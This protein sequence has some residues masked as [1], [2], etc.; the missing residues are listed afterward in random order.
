MYIDGHTIVL[1]GGILSAIIAFITL[2]WKLFKWINHQKEQDEEIKLLKTMH[3]QD[4]KDLKDK[5]EQDNNSTQDEQTIVIYGLLACLK[6]LQ[7]QGCNGPVTEAI[8]KIE[9]HINQKAHRKD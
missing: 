4:I 9:K 7:E 2:F 1:W 3:K 5:H 8:G 6:G